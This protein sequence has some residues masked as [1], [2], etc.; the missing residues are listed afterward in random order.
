MEKLGIINPVPYLYDLI[1]KP[2]IVKLKWGMEYKGFLVSTDSYMNVQLASTEEYAD[3][4][5]I[6]SVGELFIR[7]NNVM[8]IQKHPVSFLRFWTVF[9]L[10]RIIF[11]FFIVNLQTAR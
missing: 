8:Y 7:C 9:L 1:G 3:G 5:F 4:K 6:G 11:D 10:I 2:V